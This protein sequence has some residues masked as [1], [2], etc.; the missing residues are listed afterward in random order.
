M[1]VLVIGGDG[2]CG[3]ATSLYLSA[4]GHE[5]TILDSLA[6]RAW[7][8]EHGLDSLVPIASA[9]R[10]VDEWTRVTRR[11]VRLETVDATDYEALCRVVAEIAPDAIVHFGQQRSAPFSMI[12]RDHAVRT[13]VNNTVGN[14]NVLWALREY[15]PDAHLVKLGTMGE[16]GT[17]NIDIEEGFLVVEHQGRSDRLPFPKQPG[18]FYH[19]TKV[20][21]SDQLFFACRTWGLRA[22]DLNQ[23]I[24]Y[25]TLTAETAASPALANRYDY[26][27]I[28]GTVLNRFCVQAALGHPLTIYGQGGQTRGFLDIRDTVRC[29]EI[30]LEH[31]AQAGE[32]RVFN[33][34]TEMFSVAELAE[35][36]ARV[37]AGL[38]LATE[39]VRLPNP[40]SEREEHY[41]NARN[42]NL[43]ALGLDP[44][45][46]G[47]A[48][49]AGLIAIAAAHRERIDVRLIPPRV[50]WRP[51]HDAPERAVAS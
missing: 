13:H 45:P 48:T 21:D 10:R 12:D 5:V 19:L 31:P 42:T 41:Y 25:G 15:A 44:T 16:Y 51:P 33:Q 29:V 9:R 43:R 32:Y 39:I 35:R 1:K 40:R 28:F 11:A 23:G 30:A 24:V 7:D 17:P 26:D 49:I 27:H 38:G 18:S 36:V 50:A 20:S 4:R 47:D 3:W 8:R 14:L 34:F 22:T 37:A 46:L 6:R 2:Y